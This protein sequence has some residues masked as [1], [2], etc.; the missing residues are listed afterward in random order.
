MG[1]TWRHDP[2]DD[3]SNFGRGK[4]IRK[5][6]KQVKQERKAERQFEREL[7]GEDSDPKSDGTRAHR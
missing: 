2:Y 4:K 3:D 1:N 7:Y 6:R 5:A